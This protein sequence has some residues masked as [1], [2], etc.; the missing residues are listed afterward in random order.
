[1]GTVYDNESNGTVIRINIGY[2]NQGEVSRQPKKSTRNK[3]THPA[4][5]VLPPDL[6]DTTMAEQEI[7]DFIAAMHSEQFAAQTSKAADTV[8]AF[9]DKFY[10]PDMLFIRPSG[11][12]LDMAM[13]KGMWLSDDVVSE[14]N[15]LVSI[16]TVKVLG[17]GMAAIATFTAHEKFSYKG[18]P[19]SL[20]HP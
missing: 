8:Q 4:A 13:A 15:A 9:F 20:C 5:A 7:K 19:V 16:D 3:K 17:C 1:M 10:A 11:N 12:P 18:N 6:S 14:A 2:S